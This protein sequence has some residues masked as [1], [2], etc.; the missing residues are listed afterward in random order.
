MFWDSIIPGWRQEMR[1]LG[2]RL[3]CIS[4]CIVL[5]Q[6]TLTW[7]SNFY[8]LGWI[9]VSPKLILVWRVTCAQV[10]AAVCRLREICR[11]VRVSFRW[12][13]F[14]LTVQFIPRGQQCWIH[15]GK[16]STSAPSAKIIHR[17]FPVAAC[18]LALQISYT[19][20]QGQKSK[21]PF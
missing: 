12:R 11:T 14:T 18:C 1:T 17:I 13:L 4:E 10:G 7:H 19:D 8:S 9:V 15:R 5:E 6:L 3:T 2:K 21:L 20:R 16:I